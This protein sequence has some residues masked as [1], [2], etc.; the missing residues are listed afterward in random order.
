MQ[1]P[2]STYTL[3]SNFKE[4]P[5]I[6]IGWNNFW[7]QQCEISVLRLKECPLILSMVYDPHLKELVPIN[8]SS[9]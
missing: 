5:F 7:R 2:T 4:N 1:R 9:K 8:S 6:Q 3:P